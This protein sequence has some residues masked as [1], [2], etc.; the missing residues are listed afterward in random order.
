MR[1]AKGHSGY[2]IKS[3]YLPKE[4]GEAGALWGGDEKIREG[5]EKEAFRYLGPSFCL[6]GHCKMLGSLFAA[7]RIQVSRLCSTHQALQ[8]SLR[9]YLPEGCH[10]LISTKNL[11]PLWD[12][13]NEKWGEGDN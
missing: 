4:K 10:F 11:Y 7:P 5:E 3:P 13:N 12:Q 8:P 2:G 9:V 1:Q 6:Q